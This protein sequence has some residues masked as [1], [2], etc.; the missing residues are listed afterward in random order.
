MTIKA[1][2]SDN[3]GNL[4]TMSTKATLSTDGQMTIETKSRSAH[5]T[6]G[7]K[8]HIIVVIYDAAGNAIWVTKDYKCTTRGSICDFTTASSGTDYWVE[9]CPP[10]AGQLG[11]NLDI[12]HSDEGLGKNVAVILQSI[13]ESINSA[14]E[15]KDAAIAR[16]GK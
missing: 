7:L 2:E 6:E 16:G 14:Q 10:L 3:V 9:R 1:R 4:K 12:I 15:L 5:P 8:G 11:D 13:I